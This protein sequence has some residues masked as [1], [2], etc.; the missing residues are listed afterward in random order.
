MVGEGQ[1]GQG[2]VTF[3]KLAT[4]GRVHGGLSWGP[5]GEFKRDFGGRIRIA[6][7][8]TGVG[9]M[10]C[11]CVR[12]QGTFAKTGCPW[13][14]D[15]RSWCLWSMWIGAEKPFFLLSLGELFDFL[16]ID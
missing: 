9:E 2:Q 6:H 1:R 15:S 12:V 5:G 7:G 13:C 10:E 11:V 3:K 8:W 4:A 16:K 14:C